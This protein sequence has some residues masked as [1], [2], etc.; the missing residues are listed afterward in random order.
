MLE[1]ENAVLK[2]KISQ[3]MISNTQVEEQNAELNKERDFLREE[4]RTLRL[5]ISDFV[6]RMDRHDLDLETNAIELHPETS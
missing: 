1:E 4:N 5:L 6:A 3:L 2:M